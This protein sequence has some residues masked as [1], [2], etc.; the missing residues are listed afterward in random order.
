MDANA[1][2]TTAYL[3]FI[4]IVLTLALAPI[5]RAPFRFT[6]RAVTDIWYAI[7]RMLG[8]EALSRRLGQRRALDFIDLAEHLESA[9]LYDSAERC[10]DTATRL[11]TGG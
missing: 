4:G 10:R 1:I 7:R 9:G 2:I 8:V 5:D 3:A 11:I 6:N